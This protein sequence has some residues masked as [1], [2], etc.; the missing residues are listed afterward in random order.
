VTGRADWAA[1]Y[2]GRAGPETLL[3]CGAAKPGRELGDAESEAICR[4]AR[5][6]NGK[7]VPIIQGFSTDGHLYRFQHLSPDGTLYVSKVFDIR[8][9][10]ELKFVYNVLIQQIQTAIELSPPVTTVESS[11]EGKKTTVVKDA[12]ESFWRISNLPPLAPSE[13]ALD[14]PTMD[15]SEY[16]M[17]RAAGRVGY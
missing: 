16:L 7:A 8:D 4:H 13:D 15:F 5:Q 2:N 12:T 9:D 17:L 1:G 6:I 14:D 10:K 11:P 3:L